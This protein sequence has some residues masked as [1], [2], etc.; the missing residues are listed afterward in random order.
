MSPQPMDDSLSEWRKGLVAMDLRPNQD[1]SRRNWSG[2]LNA[3]ALTLLHGD[4]LPF[5]STSGKAH[6]PNC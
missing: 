5:R 6:T 2:K 4:K 3:S 1:D